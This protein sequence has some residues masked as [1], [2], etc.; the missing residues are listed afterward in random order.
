MKYFIP[1]W[2]DDQRWWQDTTVPYYQ[3][4]NKTEFDDMISLMGMHLENDLDYRLI[5]LNHA[6]NLRTFYI[7]MTY[8]RQSIG[9]CLMK[10]KDSVT[11]RHKRLIIT[12]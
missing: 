4:Q 6:P 5:V 11:M 8:M 10:F 9:L 7:D 12:T 2:H 1:A 3:L